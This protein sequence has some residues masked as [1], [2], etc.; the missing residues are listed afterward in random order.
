MK[1]LQAMKNTGKMLLEGNADAD[2]FV[3]EGQEEGVECLKNDN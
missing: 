1:V 2:A 3:V